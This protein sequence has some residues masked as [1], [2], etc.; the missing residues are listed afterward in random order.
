MA[1]PARTAAGDDALEAAKARACRAFRDDS[2]WDSSSVCEAAEEAKARLRDR[3]LLAERRLLP[4]CVEGTLLTKLP[5]DAP[6]GVRTRISKPL[7]ARLLDARRPEAGSSLLLSPE[8]IP[9]S[10]LQ[11]CSTASWNIFAT[12]AVGYVENVVEAVKRG[13][14][15]TSTVESSFPPAVNVLFD[16][17]LESPALGRPRKSGPA[18]PTFDDVDT[19][20][21]PLIRDEGSR[22]RRNS[23]TSAARCN[24]G[25]SVPPCSSTFVLTAAP[26][27][28]DAAAERARRSSTQGAFA[29]TCDDSSAGSGCSSVGSSPG[30]YDTGSVVVGL[31]SYFLF[32]ETARRVGG[33][34]ALETLLLSRNPTSSS[35]SRQHQLDD[36]A[37]VMWAH[38]L[39]AERAVLL[40]AK[41]LTSAPST[42]GSSKAYCTALK[43]ASPPPM[44]TDSL[45]ACRSPHA[46]SR[47]GKKIT[48]LRELLGHHAIGGQL[49]ASPPASPPPA[50]IV[51]T[52]TTRSSAAIRQRVALDATPAARLEEQREAGAI[53]M[54]LNKIPRLTP[55]KEPGS[56]SLSEL[57]EQLASVDARAVDKRTTQS[58]PV[59]PLLHD[60]ASVVP[61]PDSWSPSPLRSNS[62]LQR[63]QPREANDLVDDGT[64]M[65]GADVSGGNVTPG[66]FLVAVD[67]ANAP[68]AVAAVNEPVAAAANELVVAR[69]D[70][71]Q[72]ALSMDLAAESIDGIAHA[73]ESSQLPA[74][75]DPI[76]LSPVLTEPP[77]QRVAATAALAAMRKGMHPSHAANKSPGATPTIEQGKTEQQAPIEWT[78]T[79]DAGVRTSRCGPPVLVRISKSVVRATATDD[80]DKGTMTVEEVEKQPPAVPKLENPNAAQ[81]PQKLEVILSNKD[82]SHIIHW[83]DASRAIVISDRIE[84]V[85]VIMPVYFNS[86]ISKDP[87]DDSAFKAFLRQL[88]YYGFIKNGRGHF[89]NKDAAIKTVADIHRARRYTAEVNARLRREQAKANPRTE[90]ENKSK[91]PSTRARLRDKSK[92]AACPPASKRRRRLPPNKAPAPIRPEDFFPDEDGDDGH[93]SIPD[94]SESANA[95]E[96]PPPP[97][98]VSAALPQHL[99]IFTST[100]SPYS[101][102]FDDVT[103]FFPDEG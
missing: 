10:I 67:A 98:P 29:R 14:V 47:G 33:E 96:P 24:A 23:S 97:Q 80:D 26:Q 99:A 38:V 34:E 73:P 63:Q 65:Q 27:I 11:L 6:L 37:R 61:L 68:V 15:V 103:N 64:L 20:S 79:N 1:W 101:M 82:W 32:K 41:N 46:R 8:D 39:E 42:S 13:P 5:V 19:F 84:F 102:L 69:R 78:T 70:S 83:D 4:E 100:A 62:I 88:N 58:S 18:M 21:T 16:K 2:D 95:A 48:E 12:I 89:A 49:A 3:R 91:T 71:T 86:R 43:V 90:Q 36:D 44:P 7:Y 60:V 30:G 66:M 57:E 55:L 35:S 22:K 75:A 85:R 28:A 77:P 31:A 93:A 81:F 94:D 59:L 52:V 51:R 25:S 54:S 40:E 45:G 87:K 17:I 72:S 74:L 50:S 76:R 9:K 56:S 53:L 92:K